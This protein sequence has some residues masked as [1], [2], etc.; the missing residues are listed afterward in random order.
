MNENLVL[1]NGEIMPEHEAF[2]EVNDRGHNFGD[3]VFEIV[4]V[5]NGRAFALLPHMNNLFESVIQAKIPAVYMIEE[6]VEFHE[7]LIQATGL[8]EC[9][10]YTQITRGAGMYNLAFPDPVG[11]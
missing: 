11:R 2:I 5:Y 6:F 8:S 7:A 4:P 10:I 9:N 3:G 1:I